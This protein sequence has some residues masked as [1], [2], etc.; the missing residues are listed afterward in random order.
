MKIL[1]ATNEGQGQR[2]N[3]FCF[4]NQHEP[5]G[6]PSECDNQRVDGRCGCRRS[7]AGMI[8]L[9]STTTMTVIEDPNVTP[10]S[11]K[12][13]LR[14]MMITGEWD[15]HLSPA[16]LQAIIDEDAGI[17]INLANTFEVGAIVERRGDQ[18]Q[19]RIPRS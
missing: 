8:T 14:T 16:D 3:D 7:M 13:S 12:E 1:V 19:T 10:E 11:L 9:K 18:F 17:L 5:V 6:F 2:K 4:A 15:K